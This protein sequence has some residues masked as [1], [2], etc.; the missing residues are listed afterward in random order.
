MSKTEQEL[1]DFTVHDA[2]TNV[3]LTTPKRYGW[4]CIIC[5]AEVDMFA[6]HADARLAAER[7][8]GGAYNTE[9][10]R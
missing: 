3:T 9:E 6:T 2:R 1:V 8:N 7:H 4:H 5:G 10:V